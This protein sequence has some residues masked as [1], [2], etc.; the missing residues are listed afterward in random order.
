MRRV[1]LHGSR[2]YRAPHV[3]VPTAPALVRAGLVGEPGGG[4]R[5]VVLEVPR[6]HPEARVLANAAGAVGPRRRVP[7]GSAEYEFRVVVAVAGVFVPDPPFPPPPLPPPPHAPPE[8]DVQEAPARRPRVER[9]AEAQALH[10]LAEHAV[11]EVQQ[12]RPSAESSRAR[13]ILGS[14]PDAGVRPDAGSRPRPRPRLRRRPR[15]PRRVLFRDALG[16]ASVP[17]RAQASLDLVLD[18]VGCAD[19]SGVSLASEPREVASRGRSLPRRVRRRGR[20]RRVALGG[21][22]PAERARLHA[23]DALAG[24]AGGGEGQARRLVPRVVRGAEDLAPPSVVPSRR[25]RRHSRRLRARVVVVRMRARTGVGCARGGLDV[26]ERR[27]GRGGSERVRARR[28]R[29]LLSD[30][31]VH[32]LLPQDRRWGPAAGARD[33][34]RGHGREVRR[35]PRVVLIRARGVH[36]EHVRRAA[37]EILG[38]DD[39]DAPALAEEP[40]PRLEPELVDGARGVER[41]DPRS[42]LVARHGPTGRPWRRPRRGVVTRTMARALML[43]PGA[44]ISRRGPVERAASRRASHFCSTLSLQNCTKKSTWEFR[45]C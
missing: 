7:R 9:V 41:D 1:P 36:E 2:D 15:R 27:P 6:H 37:P 45:R 14:R 4:V 23:A 28:Q 10:H 33:A 44:Q 25:R 18:D 38:R 5:V 24:L 35:E 19:E 22:A 42:K 21:E 30:A 16:L 31:V 39:D 43:A 8:R 40:R 17:S 34:R 3:P 32:P 26:R 13:R 11:G 29:A 20:R 12:E